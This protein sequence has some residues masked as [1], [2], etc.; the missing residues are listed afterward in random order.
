MLEAKAY[1]AAHNSSFIA[2]PFV[3]VLSCC[4]LES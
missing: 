2:S 4:L 1:S 3:L